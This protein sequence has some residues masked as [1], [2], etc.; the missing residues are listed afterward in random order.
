MDELDLVPLSQQLVTALFGEDLEVAL[1]TRIGG[2][3][4]EVTVGRQPI[5]RLLGLQQRQRLPPGSVLMASQ[6]KSPIC[7]KGINR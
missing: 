5:E 6:E 3:H 2:D 7:L 4:F 1:R